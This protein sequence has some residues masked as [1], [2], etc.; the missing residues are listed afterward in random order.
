LAGSVFDV[1]FA[2]FPRE[3]STAFFA[4]KATDL[5]ADFAAFLRTAHRAFCAAA[6]RAFPSGLIDRLAF[7]AFRGFSCEVEPFGRPR[8]TEGAES[9]TSISKTLA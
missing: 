8:F 6:I 5:F 1:F 9:A 3:A 4:T 7:F 2:D